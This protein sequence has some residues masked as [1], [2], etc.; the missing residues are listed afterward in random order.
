[1]QGN[2]SF[3]GLILVVGQGTMDFSGGGNGE[4]QGG[5]FVAKTRDVSGNL[6]SSLGSPRIDWKRD[7][8]VKAYRQHLRPSRA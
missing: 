6:L 1:M 4:I 5:I 8:P 7:C 3:Y 2:G